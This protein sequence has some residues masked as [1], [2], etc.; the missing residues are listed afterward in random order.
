MAEVTFSQD[1][2][3]NLTDDI[4]VLSK[5]NQLLHSEVRKAGEDKEDIEAHLKETIRSVSEVEK[6]VELKDQEN[7]NWRTV[8]GN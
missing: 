4:S 5:E 2:I 1:N 8:F 7:A 6:I 3:R